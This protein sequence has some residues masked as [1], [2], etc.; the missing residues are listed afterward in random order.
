LYVYDY[1]DDWHHRIMLRRHMRDPNASYPRCIE[2]TIRAARGC[3]RV[4]RLR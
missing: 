2:G 1:G 4:L 3:G